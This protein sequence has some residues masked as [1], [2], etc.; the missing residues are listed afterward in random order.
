MNNKLEVL[1]EMWLQ[2]IIEPA[3]IISY[4]KY[5]DYELILLTLGGIS[6]QSKDKTTKVI[7]ENTR[8]K[9]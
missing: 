4:L 5:L 2:K 7:Y 1:H 3:H 8:N 6:I 9:I